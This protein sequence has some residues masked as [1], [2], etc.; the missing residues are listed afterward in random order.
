MTCELLVSWE[1]T[2]GMSNYKH[3]LSSLLGSINVASSTAVLREI[4]DPRHTIT[5]PF[6]HTVGLDSNQTLNDRA[7]SVPIIR[8]VV[9][10][11]FYDLNI[12]LIY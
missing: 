5:S 10:Q 11:K 1:A 12:E 3:L 9:S 7:N 6:S 4:K 8:L 2:P